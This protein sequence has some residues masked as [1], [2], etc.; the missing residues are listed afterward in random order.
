MS[1]AAA[2]AVGNRAAFAQAAPVRVAAASDLKFVLGELVAQYQRE[3]G[4]Q[5][6]LSLGSS[7]NFAQQIRHGLPVDLYMA[8]DERYVFQLADAGLT[9]GRGAIYA[10]GRIALL[11]PKASALELDARLQVLRSALPSLR[12][13]AIANPEHAPY[14]RAAREALQ[15]M[16]LWEQVAPKLVLGENIA[17][18][19]QFVTSGAAPAGITAL[20]L[21]VAPEVAAL[22][23]S[24]VVPAD[25]HRPLR[26]RMVLLAGARPAAA[27]FYRF[28]QGAAARA[29]LQR[30][31]FGTELPN[32]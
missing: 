28:L 20:S 11:V 22:T 18:A 17:Q 23:R 26:Q 12:T 19:T 21:A 7:G 15:H 10:M 9:Q 2:A 31:G 8:A 27:G 1:I 5:V 29:V 4:Q 30:Y 16:G 13:F 3:S 25:W 32:G 24:M 14:G 6:Q